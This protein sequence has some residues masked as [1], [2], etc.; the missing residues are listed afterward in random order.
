MELSAEEPLRRKKLERK[1]V[2]SPALHCRQKKKQLLFEE[3]EKRMKAFFNLLSFY[4]E[5]EEEVC[6]CRKKWIIEEGRY[7]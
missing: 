4:Q 1:V 3:E 7:P 2:D 5:E 6:S